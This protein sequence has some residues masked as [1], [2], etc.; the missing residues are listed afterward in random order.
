MGRKSYE[1]GKLEQQCKNSIKK[2]DFAQTIVCYEKMFELTKDYHF[3]GR[4]LNLR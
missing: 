4:S 3:N 2:N 1:L